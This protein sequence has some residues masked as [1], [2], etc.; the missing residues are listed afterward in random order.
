MSNL[1]KTLVNRLLK[2]TINQ[3]LPQIVKEDFNSDYKMFLYTLS[4]EQLMNS[5]D[6]EED[7]VNLNCYQN[8]LN[9]EC[10]RVIL[11]MFQNHS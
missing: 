9:R 6:Y 1:K 4:T 8:C 2:L 7:R 11:K 5:V 3:E 10:L